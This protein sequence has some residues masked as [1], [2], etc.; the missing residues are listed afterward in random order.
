MAGPT[1]DQ[2]AQIQAGAPGTA[3]LGANTRV[4]GQPG[5][6]GTQ[7]DT[8]TFGNGAT[9]FWITVNTRVRVGGV[10]TVSASSTGAGTLPNGNP[11][12]VLVTNGDGRIRTL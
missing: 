3:M 7:S 1:V 6:L 8:L 10:F 5:F 12:T 2:A 9:G 11:V 4:K